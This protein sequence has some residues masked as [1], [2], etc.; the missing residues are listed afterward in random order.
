M[1]HT[2]RN[3]FFCRKDQFARAG[4][5][6]Q[7]LVIGIDLHALQTHNPY[8]F[9]IGKNPVVYSGDSSVAVSIAQLWTNKR[10]KK[11]AI[12]PVEFFKRKSLTE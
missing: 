2:V 9:K 6:G 12:V 4:Y 5:P 8:E 7:V 3:P 11:V 1:I 10:G